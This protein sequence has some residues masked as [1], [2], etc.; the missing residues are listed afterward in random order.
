MTTNTVR[1]HELIDAYLAELGRTLRGQPDADDLVAELADHLCESVDR[2]VARGSDATVAQQV[3]IARLGQ[4]ALVARALVS[5]RARRLAQPSGFTVAA[6]RLGAAAAALWV[7]LGVAEFVASEVVLDFP[8][9]PVRQLIFAIGMAAILATALLI[10][11]I[12]VR[13]GGRRDLPTLSV[14][15]CGILALVAGAGMQW[16]F[17]LWGGFLSVAA[18]VANSQRLKVATGSPSSLALSL[19]WPVGTV[20]VLVGQALHWGPVGFYEDYPLA[21]ATGV[22]VGCALSAIGCAVNARW[23]AAEKVAMR[24]LATA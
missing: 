15:M 21:I 8:D 1:G 10:L 18:L 2:A 17:I 14:A 13:S 22:A 19:A 16:F 9:G 4:P 3:A 6:G 11:G 24:D 7:I 12:S 5:A 23:L 20:V